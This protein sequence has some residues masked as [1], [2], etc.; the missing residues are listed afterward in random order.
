M[1]ISSLVLIALLAASSQQIQIKNEELDAANDALDAMSPE[2]QA[3]LAA[4]LGITG[5]NGEISAAEVGAQSTTTEAAVA[6]SAAA[7]PTSDAS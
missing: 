4:K 1:K 3:A 6:E 7:E 5:A 2:E